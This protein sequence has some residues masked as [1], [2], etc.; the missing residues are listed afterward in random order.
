MR[1]AGEAFIN[2]VFFS[3]PT[4]AQ[5]VKRNQ[6]IRQ[7]GLLF[8]KG[9]N[10]LFSGS[11][12]A[13]ARTAVKQFWANQTYFITRLLV[14]NRQLLSSLLPANFF[15]EVNRG[16]LTKT[17]LLATL[18]EIEQ[19]LQ[20][21][22]FAQ[23]FIDIITADCRSGTP[24]SVEQPSQ[25]PPEINFVVGDSIDFS[26]QQAKAGRRVVI[27]DAANAQRPGAGAY[28]KGTFQE[29]L[30]RQTDLYLKM[31]VDF[32]NVLQDL[33]NQKKNFCKIDPEDLNIQVWQ[34]QA[35][36]LKLILHFV[37]ESIK[38]E[39][40]TANPNFVN[41]FLQYADAIYSDMQNR[42][43]EIDT[44]FA[45]NCSLLNNPINNTNDLFLND[46]VNLKLLEEETARVTAVEVAA[47]DR[48]TE[49]KYD[50][51]ST[52]HS[53]LRNSDQE[54]TATKLITNSIIFTLETA[55][56]QRADVIVLNAF[57]CGAFLN[58]PE[59]VAK[60]F[61]KVLAQYSDKLKGVQIQFMDLDES[62]CWTFAHTM[63]RVLL[64]NFR[65]NKHTRS[66][67]HIDICPTVYIIDDKPPKNEAFIE[68][69]D[70]CCT[71]ET[72]YK[73]TKLAAKPHNREGL[74]NCYE[75][76]LKFLLGKGITNIHT[77]LLGSGGLHAPISNCIN[78][79][80]DAVQKLAS[81]SLPTPK[82][83]V[84]I[85][86]QPIYFEVINYL[87]TQT[88]FR[89]HGKELKRYFKIIEPNIKRKEAFQV[90]RL[91]SDFSAK[92]GNYQEYST[93][94]PN[95]Y[96]GRAPLKQVAQALK[97]KIPHLALVVSVVEDFEMAGQG[98]TELPIQTALDWLALG[99][100]H[101]QL[102]VQDCRTAD[103]PRHELAYTLKKMHE[104]IA[105]KG[106]VYVHCKAG[107]TRS[108]TV[109]FAY[110]KKHGNGA[111][112]PPNSHWDTILK[113]LTGI[114]DVVTLRDLNLDVANGAIEILDAMTPPQLPP[115]YDLL[116]KIDSYLQTSA[117]K[118]QFVQFIWFK[119][120]KNIA[121]KN[122]DLLPAAK[123]ILKK[124]KHA[125]TF[126]DY[127][128]ALDPRDAKIFTT[129]KSNLFLELT[130]HLAKIF[131]CKK[132]DILRTLGEKSN[133]S[134]AQEPSAARP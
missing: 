16:N 122:R 116:K 95:L 36:F 107:I 8:L 25:E 101:I 13:D 110:L 45:K 94:N 54:E 66:Q 121:L 38:N 53:D 29:A 64:G 108:S 126:K 68:A 132:D 118:S 57:G 105:A 79:L 27:M 81:T 37:I 39:N 128:K 63:S 106:G 88:N 58:E 115:E 33:V 4:S 34:F 100:M 24:A 129:E 9:E 130:D 92:F 96:L 102:V 76:Q 5:E 26:R 133:Q 46:A 21:E 31:L 114:R 65:I 127:Q 99:V 44:G 32:R 82:I 15:N 52:F 71:N 43:F 51:A 61:G 67:A 1:Q 50:R 47:P 6:D 73:F 104:V 42:V 77:C 11:V 20:Q 86:F 55:I 2:Y 89:T 30:T 22:K 23:S 49:G 80:T 19:N 72:N 59:F 125:T 14:Q 131:K 112:L 91:R 98:F 40:F 90:G 41:D 60:I 134:E 124:L 93:I 123:T 87:A 17:T 62:K 56:A 117:A 74:A 75:V 120:I 48:R 83:Y 97:E 18:T 85:P 7:E 69:W 70:R 3:K 113:H 10:L 78:A 109:V 12:G 84:H 103:Y 28:E 111:A 35:R 119:E